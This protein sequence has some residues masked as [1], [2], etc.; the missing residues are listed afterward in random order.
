ML[1]PTT[2]LGFHYY[3]DDRHYG[4]A[5]LASWL[6][7]LKSFGAGWLVLRASASRSVP[8][9]FLRGLL[10]EGVEPIVHLPEQVGRITPA[11]IDPLLRAYAA[12]GVRHVVLFDKPNVRANWESSE[13]SRIGLIDRFLD[14]ALPLWS[15][16]ADLGMDPVVAPLEPG[17]DYWDTAF[18]EG[19]LRGLARRGQETLLDRLA[20]G[21][22]AWT[23][24]RPLDWGAGGPQ[25]WPESRP[26]HTPEGSQDQRGLRLPDWY[27][28]IAQSSIGKALPIYVL[29]GGALPGRTA[30]DDDS[31]FEQN[32]GVARWLNG[33]DAP[34]TLRAFSFYLLTASPSSPE[35]YAAWYAAPD[36]PR[37][38]VDIVRGAL[39]AAAKSQRPKALAHY[40]LLPAGTTDPV[41]W[42]LAGQVAV[43]SPGA[44]GM[45]P[46]EARLAERVTLL[47]A[48]GAVDE[49]TAAQLERV[50]CRIDRIVPVSFAATAK[51]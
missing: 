40:I 12:W 20:L 21:A 42:A 49:R 6:P 18:L 7:V 43:R 32:A 8:E 48:P 1:L 10:D 2:A 50:G 27:A 25:A 31:S 36:Q 41:L 9:E 13:W 3:P 30:T 28:A 26:Y 4:P 22:Y 15:L 11:D 39:L 23:Y 14:R 33:S 38:D 16:Q 29:G 34:P 24:G 5:D 17:G 19:T 47:G 45:S 35:A 51:S 37:R 46:A 44:V